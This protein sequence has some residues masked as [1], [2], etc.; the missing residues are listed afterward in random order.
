M[1]KE[2]L[3]LI[4]VVL[5][6][7][8]IVMDDFPFYHKMKDPSTQFFIAIIF[9]AFIYYDT[10]FGFIMGLVLMLIYFEIYKN[11][12]KNKNI[13]NEKDTFINKEKQKVITNESITASNEMNYISEEHLLAAQ[14]NI[15]DEDNYL[16][17]IKGFEKGFNNE[18]V[19]GVQGFDVEKLNYQGFDKCNEYSSWQTE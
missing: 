8:I 19:Y 10:T 18:S 16:S 11:I 6:I 3:R 7:M 14:N 12:K 1:I 4:A 9:V 15:Y 2:T 13:E 5:L 17:E